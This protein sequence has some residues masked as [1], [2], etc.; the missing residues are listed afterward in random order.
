MARHDRY[1]RDRSWHELPENPVPGEPSM[2]MALFSH[3][4]GL[5][6][7]QADVHVQNSINARL[8]SNREPMTFQWDSPIMSSMRPVNANIENV[9]QSVVD[10]LVARIGSMQVKA[11][12]Y[13]RGADFDVYLKGKQLDKY[14]WGQFQHLGVFA[15]SR[16][17]FR[18]ALI[19]G[20][21]FLKIGI[22]RDQLVAER[23]NPDE[24][25]VDQR[26]CISGQYPTQ[27]HHRKLM[28]RAA[29]L[30]MF[31][32]HEEFIRDVSCQD[33]TSY[34]TPTDNNV[35]VVESWKLPS[36][37]GASDGRH[38]VCIENRTLASEP[39]TRDRAPFVVL[40]W[41]NP[42]HGFYGRS[43]VSDVIGY[44]IQ[45]NNLNT[46]IRS[47]QDVMCVPRVFIDQATQVLDTRLDNQI[48]KVVRYRGTMPEAVTW[49][50]FNPEIYNERERIWNRAHE[51]QGVSMMAATN[52]L[53]TQAR[54]DSSD[55][56]RE[57]NAINDDR[58]ND[59]A[60]AL[61]EWFLAVAEE[62]VRCSKELHSG[63]K[64]SKTKYHSGKL[65]EQIDWAEVDLDEDMYVMQ[66]AASGVVNMSPAA[67]RDRVNDWHA[68]GIITTDQLKSM[69]GEPD[70]EHLSDKASST[71]DAVAS[72][73]QLMLKGKVALPDPHMNLGLGLQ[74]VLE[75]YNR[76]IPMNVP[77]EV[78]QL[79]R[80]WMLTAESYLN[81]QPP[82][83]PAPMPGPG[84]P[85]PGMAPGPVAD[86]AMAGMMPP[87]PAMPGGM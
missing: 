76:L 67:R 50:A 51:S 42:L 40:R 58:F 18:D 68:R 25:I 61:E 84:M 11:T 28:T 15:L 48:G 9:V 45:L 7:D 87:G 3:V 44:Q 66:I 59:R 47:G 35:V 71:Y 29:L 73:V 83:P 63:K 53:P 75:E 14:L 80:N 49:T 4:K 39:Y 23:V 26:E 43:V 13:T 32:D 85:G 78:M 34:R 33:Y 64:P 41:C 5:E 46:S 10:T 77:E 19:Y 86:P 22:D 52:K 21:G 54:L 17:V 30:G 37:P 82:P 65:V 6:Q 55:A 62:I 31:P 56:L 12:V 79:L 38:V 8:Y 60:Q 2:H 74:C 24:M 69:S 57:Y 27:L 1:D 72:Q 81:A 36:Y 20:T 16:E 70:L